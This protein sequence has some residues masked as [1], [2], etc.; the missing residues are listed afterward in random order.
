MV[1][2]I[3]YEFWLPGYI[4]YAVSGTVLYSKKGPRY[5]APALPMPSLNM[6]IKLNVY[7][8]SFLVHRESV[9]QLVG[10]TEDA[11]VSAWC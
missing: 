4:Q 5:H 1:R 3:E 9:A 7:L 10:D 11:E 8:R 2:H 6:K